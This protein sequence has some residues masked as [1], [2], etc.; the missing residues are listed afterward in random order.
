MYLLAKVPNNVGDSYKATVAGLLSMM[1]TVAAGLGV[2]NIFEAKGFSLKVLIWL[3]YSSDP[4]L[5]APTAE[6]FCD[7]VGEGSAGEDSGTLG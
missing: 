7:I 1:S 2:E 4:K 3:Q 6:L 5:P